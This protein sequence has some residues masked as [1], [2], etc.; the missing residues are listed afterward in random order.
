MNRSALSPANLW[1]MVK[2]SVTAWIDDFAPSMGAS[3]AYYTAFSIAPLLI[4]V[5]AIAGFVWGAGGRQR[6]SLRPARG[7]PRRRGNESRRRH[8]GERQQHGRRRRSPPSSAWRCSSSARRPCSP[9]CK[10]TSTGSG[11]RPP[12]R[13]AEGLWGLIRSRVLS[14]GLVVSIGFLLLV[15]LVVSAAL[16]ALGKWWGGIFGDVRV[17]VA[18]AR[19]RRQPRRGRRDVRA[20]VQDPAARQDRVARRVDRR[21]RHCAAVRDRQVPGRLVCR[22][23]AAW[24]RASVRRDR[25]PCSWC[26]STTPRRS[27]C[28]APS[29]RGSTR[30]AS[31][32]A[33]A[34]RSRPPPRKRLPRRTSR[35]AIAHRPAPA[36]KRAAA[37]AC[38]ASRPRGGR[39]GLLLAPYR[40]AHRRR[41]RPRRVG[42]QPFRSRRSPS[43]RA[44]SSGRARRGAGRGRPA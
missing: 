2:E 20:H 22:Q 16:A 23:D 43:S 8:G 31:G 5:I 38:R 18:R 17:A 6:L 11:K 24:R 36:A 34:R 32:R 1:S 28:S 30:I 37:G 40:R 14:L 42:R 9:S 26:G 33:A 44:A 29:S 4:I 39:A 12:S 10:A 25:S 7:H 3:I 35:T 19:F 15:S 21:R 13:S 41:H 27:S